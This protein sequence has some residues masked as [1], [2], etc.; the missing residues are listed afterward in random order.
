M[1]R[2]GVVG[3]GVI[4]RFYLAAVGHSPD[5]TLAAVCDL[6]PAALRDVPVP[7]YRDHRSMLAAGGLDAVIVTAPNDVHAAVCRD[8]LDAGLPVC[9]EKPLAT[10]L[11]DGEDLVSRAAARNVA[12]FTAFHRRYNANVLALREELVDAAPIESVKVRYLERIEEHVGGDRWYLD[13]A[14]CGGGCVADNGPNA[15]DLVRL[16]LGPVALRH[17]RITRDADGVDRLATLELDGA[18]VE[19]DWSF[20]GEAKDIEVRLTDGTRLYADMLSG[21]PEFKESL[22]HEYA[23]L[24]RD[25]AVA[26]RRK[27]AWHDGGLAGLSIVDECYRRERDAGER[28]EAPGHRHAGEG[29]GT[30]P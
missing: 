29:T 25:F 14:R 11:A 19:L 30:S 6:D 4:S 23:G 18:V 3:L 20:P 16:F 22:W 7:G 9:V 27:G 21:F 17:V 15:L 12:L 5:F 8:V 10:A 13:A 26:I 2:V 24:L 1:I 28:T